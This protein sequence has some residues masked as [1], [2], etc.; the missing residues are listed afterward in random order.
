MFPLLL[1]SFEPWRGKKE[2]RERECCNRP[3][4]ISGQMIGV[5]IL[6]VWVCPE[7]RNVRKQENIT[8]H[9]QYMFSSRRVNLYFSYILNLLASVRSE[10]P[11]GEKLIA[12]FSHLWFCIHRRGTTGRQMKGYLKDDDSR[13]TVR[14]SDW[15]DMWLFRGHL[16]LSVSGVRIACHEKGYGRYFMSV[17]QRRRLCF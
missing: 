12:F 14:P 13:D 17:S 3:L 9:V 7:D 10:S 11:A 2:E 5:W 16:H 1:C 8:L 15:L 4:Y 6:L